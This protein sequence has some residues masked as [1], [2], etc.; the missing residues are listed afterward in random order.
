[1]YIYIHIY[2]TTVIFSSPEDDV[3]SIYVQV[4]TP[5]TCVSVL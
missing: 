3:P 4:T 1:M 2:L 5:S